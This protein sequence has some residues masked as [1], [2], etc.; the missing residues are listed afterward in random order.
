LAGLGFVAKPRRDVRH[1]ANRGSDPDA[2]C[3][4]LNRHGS[5]YPPYRI[6]QVGT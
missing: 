1:C 5:N 3:P 4:L 6:V 2:W